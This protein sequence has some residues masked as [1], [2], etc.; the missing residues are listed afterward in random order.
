[1][2]YCKFFLQ[3]KELK[4]FKI[5]FTFE[6]FHADVLKSPSGLAV[7]SELSNL[8]SGSFP[9]F[10]SLPSGQFLQNW[11]VKKDWETE[12]LPMWIY[13]D[14]TWISVNTKWTSHLGM[15]WPCFFPHVMSACSWL[16][17]M[18]CPAKIRSVCTLL[19]VTLS[20]FPTTAECIFI[21]H[22]QSKHRA[23]PLNAFQPP[24]F[25][26]LT[27]PLS[28]LALS[29]QAQPCA[30]LSLI[31]ALLDNAANTPGLCLHIENLTLFAALL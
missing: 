23:K 6:D 7:F 28:T 20:L 11:P 3:N 29:Q 1:M 2:K 25:F 26:F 19:C 16:R 10:P 21:I 12:P 15:G 9:I 30:F 14:S 8:S 4:L 22:F 27:S 31:R 5:S 24:A 13:T 17:A 18:A